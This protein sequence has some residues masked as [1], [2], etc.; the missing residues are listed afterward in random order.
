MRFIAVGDIHKEWANLAR[1][2]G[3]DTADLLLVTG[4]LTNFG[5]AA[6]AAEVLTAIQRVNPN[7]LALAGNLD[8]PEVNELLAAHG[9]SLHGI[10]RRY[11]GIGLCGA[12]GS[13]PTPFATPNEFSEAELAALLAAGHR[14]VA[15]GEL[16]LVTHAPPR[17]TLTDRLRNG[18]HAG[19]SAVRDFI[20]THQPAAAICGHIHEARAEDRLGRTT[21]INPGMLK[22]GGYA[23]ITAENG[24]LRARLA[25]IHQTPS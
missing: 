1:I 7:I 14:Q 18:T 16:L 12:G 2:P 10:G 3:I 9:I 20:T 19:S 11:G 8:Q 6:D 23:V 5:N 22:D 13:N 17:S 4:D 24:Q 21:I 15:G 25:T